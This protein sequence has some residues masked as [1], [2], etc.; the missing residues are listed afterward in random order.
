MDIKAKVLWAKKDSRHGEYVWLPLMVHL[1]DTMEVAGWLW[2]HWLSKGQ[3]DYC[4]TQVRGLASIDDVEKVVRFIAAVHDIGK[5][6][7][8][9]QTQKGYHDDQELDTQLL[10]RLEKYGFAGISTL[11]L[12]ASRKTHHALAGQTILHGFGVQDDIAS[13]VGGHHGKPID[14]RVEYEEQIEGYP[15][16]YYQSERQ[17]RIHDLWLN[18]Q[19]DIFDWALE[20]SELYSTANLPELSE[21]CQVLLSG[22]II[23]ADWIASNESLFPLLPIDSFEPTDS[24][25]RFRKGIEEWNK[26]L[27]IE[28]VVPQSAEDLFYKRFRFSPREFQKKI[29]DIV[30]MVDDPGIVIVEVPTGAGKTEAALAVAE[31]VAAKMGKSGLFFGMP[32]QA[33]SNGIFPRVKD[34]LSSVSHDLGNQSIRL[35]HG[36]AALNPTMQELRQKTQ[37]ATKVDIDQDEEGEVIVNEWFS[38]RKKSTLDDVVVGTVDNFLLTALKQKHLALRHLGFSKKV[39]IIDEVHAYDAY[40]KQYLAEAIRWMGAY[41]VPVILLSATLPKET[42]KKL[43]RAYMHGR[44]VT[45]DRDINGLEETGIS[46]DYPLLTVSDGNEVRLYSDFNQDEEKAVRIED[47]AEENLISQIETS[48][49][50]GGVI[51]IVVNT[52]RRAQMLAAICREKF[53]EDTVILLHSQFLSTDRIEKENNLIN[54]IGKGASR[55]FQKIVIGTQVIEQSLDIDF[56]V[57][58]TDLCPM[59]LLIQRMG[60]LHRHAIQRPR[61]LEK[62]V[63]YVMG[64]SEDLDFEKGSRAVYGDW[65]LART[66]YYLPDVIHVPADISHLVQEVYEEKAIP[67]PSKLANKYDDFRQKMIVQQQKEVEKASTFLISKPKHKIAPQKYNLIGWLKNPD[68][69]LSDEIAS[70]QVRDIQETI[71]IIAVRKAGNG[72]SFFQNNVDISHKVTEEVV[73]QKLARQTLRLPYS[74]S[75][76]LGMQKVIQEL[77]AYNATYLS[78]WQELPW[79]KGSLGVIFDEKNRARI[80][81][82]TFE[83]DRYYG[84]RRVVADESV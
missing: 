46:E 16:N 24:D 49:E 69:S 57:M 62:P 33:T 14:D 4:F 48:I 70:A 17:D 18:V 21:P 36:K 61:G 27:P 32:T 60:R 78:S 82:T 53:G 31:I 76:G 56:D 20:Q 30:E 5:A 72:Y 6:T 42:R 43:V 67:W 7:P 19:K 8:A 50:H 10:E 26:N 35:V 54:M 13:I 38:G 25:A 11:N 41:Q 59:D 65:V 55:P 83:Y 79:L 44:G 51:G 34:W 75:Y 9:F 84:L 66:Q 63:L 12:T 40:M 39:V 37:L 23:M 15:A 47:L 77:E 22:L 71:E 58:I 2:N 80:G 3:R 74:I 29:V 45:K 81:N 1:M 52:V 64:K 28:A 68:Q 73:Q